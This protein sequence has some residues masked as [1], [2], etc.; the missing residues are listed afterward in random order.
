MLKDI[1]LPSPQILGNKHGIK[2]RFAP[3]APLENDD[4]W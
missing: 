4:D 3:D 1:H 2:L